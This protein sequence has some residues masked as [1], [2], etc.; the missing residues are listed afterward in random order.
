MR[1]VMNDKISVFLHKNTVIQFINVKLIV[2]DASRLEALLRNFVCC[3][4]T[5]TNPK[6][7]LRQISHPQIAAMMSHERKTL[8]REA[9]YTSVL[10]TCEREI[11]VR[12]YNRTE[13]TATLTLLTCTLRIYS[14]KSFCNQHS[15]YLLVIHNLY[16]LVWKIPHSILQCL[17]RI[18]WDWVTR[19]FMHINSTTKLRIKPG[20]Q[21]EFLG[22]NCRVKL[23]C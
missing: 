2:L 11:N 9:H 19:I 15:K 6:C 14:I 13:R 12:K 20:K 17:S 7:R 5:C 16:Y 3:G 10:D 8:W 4:V 1:A 21:A 18:R 23:Y 22:K